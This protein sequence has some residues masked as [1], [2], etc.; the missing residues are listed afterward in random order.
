[1]SITIPST[2][3][4]KEPYTARLNSPLPPIPSLDLPR[5][6]FTST[7][8]PFV[9]SPNPSE[10][11]RRSPTPPV[12]KPVP[13]EKL[14]IPT[15]LTDTDKRSSP[16]SPFD[17]IHEVSGGQSQYLSPPP[18]FTSLFTRS[19]TVSSFD[20][21]ERELH[22]VESQANSTLGHGSPARTPDGSDS[23][24]RGNSS[25]TP[26]DTP[27]AHIRTMPVAYSPRS[28]VISR[29]NR[30][31][32]RSL[33]VGSGI[34]GI[35]ALLDLKSPTPSIYSAKSGSNN[36]S[37]QGDARSVR[38]WKSKS[39][40]FAR[41]VSLSGRYSRPNTTESVE[42][43]ASSMA[44]WERRGSVYDSELGVSV[45]YLEEML[46]RETLI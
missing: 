21:S 45:P 41:S 39:A 1:M 2:P 44:D 8:E 14:E 15:A 5:L 46:R 9:S 32:H 42:S 4:A 25:G 35:K 37:S 24:R 17:D 10:G 3:L 27:P 31:L 6:S 38:S 30:R 28:V 33:H 13:P 18:R 36:S 19:P 16:V 29:Q 26:P 7:S 34:E 23:P 20:S 40:S 43:H 12:R 11:Q 22:S